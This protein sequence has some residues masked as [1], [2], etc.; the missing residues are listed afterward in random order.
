MTNDKFCTIETIT[1]YYNFADPSEKSMVA[2][3]ELPKY[4]FEHE[5]KF[6]PN[7]LSCLSEE[8]RDALHQICSNKARSISDKEK[9]E[10]LEEILI[11]HEGTIHHE[12]RLH[13]ISQIESKIESLES[14]KR[15]LE[16]ST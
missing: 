1:G 2:V 13:R 3:V 11:E 4:D 8:W 9:Q 6:D 15:K 12:W 14:E 5:F 7:E 16:R 10:E